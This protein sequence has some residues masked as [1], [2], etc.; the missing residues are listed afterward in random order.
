MNAIVLKSISETSLSSTA[1]VTLTLNADEVAGWKSEAQ[2]LALGAKPSP[3]RWPSVTRE[4]Y[5][6]E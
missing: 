2:R 5:N 1:T 4:E 6:D 3:R